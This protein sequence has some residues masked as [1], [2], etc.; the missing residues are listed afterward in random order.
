[1]ALST[2]YTAPAGF[3]SWKLA[4]VPPHMAAWYPGE[5]GCPG[6]TNTEPTCTPCN[7]AK[8]CETVATAG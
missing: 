4:E 1:M 3:M 6:D 2:E 8:A 7:T 5:S